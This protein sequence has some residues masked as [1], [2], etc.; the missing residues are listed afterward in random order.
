MTAMLQ[1]ELAIHG[2]RLDNEG[3]VDWDL[4]NPEHPQN[5]SEW[6]KSYNNAM[7][8]WL[9]FFMTAISNTGV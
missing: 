8:F 5:W 1:E 2:L 6:R 4:S 9:E 7:I 3:N